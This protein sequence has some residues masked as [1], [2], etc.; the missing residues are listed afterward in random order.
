M[1]SKL[2]LASGYHQIE[3]KEQHIGK[4]AFRTSRGHYEFLV[5]PFGLCNAP[6]TFQRLMNK[7]FAA[8][9]GDFFV[10]TLTIY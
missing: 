1:F 10:Y 4:T 2:D 5:M 3:V 9:I 8:H 7:V 6:A